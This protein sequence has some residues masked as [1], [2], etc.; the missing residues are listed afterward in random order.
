MLA[1][2]SIPGRRGARGRNKRLTNTPCSPVQ[3]C[4]A[5]VDDPVRYG[6]TTDTSGPMAVAKEVTDGSVDPWMGLGS[7]GPTAPAP[8]NKLYLPTAKAPTPLVGM[9]NQHHHRR[10]L[11][12]RCGAWL[13]PPPISDPHQCLC[14]GPTLVHQADQQRQ[15]LVV[16]EDLAHVRG[17]GHLRLAGEVRDLARRDALRPLFGRHQRVQPARYARRSL[18]PRS[19]DACAE[20]FNRSN[21]LRRVVGSP[22]TAAPTVPLHPVRPGRHRSEHATVDLG[23][24]RGGHRIQRRVAR[25]LAALPH[26]L[27]QRHVD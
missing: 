12:P 25:Q 13:T 4:L 6:S 19:V 21:S 11:A 15:P 7:C 9:R 3:G 17:V 16:V 1:G 20:F 14:R 23:A 2:V 24:D 26:Q 10:R 8:Q 22:T 18:D 5:Q 27:V